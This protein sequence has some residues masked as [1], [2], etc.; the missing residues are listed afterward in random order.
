ME[1]WITYALVNQKIVDI[2]KELKEKG[3]KLYLL[4]KMN[5][6][7]YEYLKTLEFRKYFEGAEI[8]GY[9]KVAK[10]D[11]KSYEL[12]F[13]KYNLKPEECLF[14]DDDDTSGN[15]RTALSLGMKALKLNPND[16][17]QLREFLEKENIL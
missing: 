15:I 13:E 11:P 5:T 10:P 4:S 9:D 1:T 7:V 3:Y 12:L 6:Y 2:A 14:I 17:V 16:D 8:S